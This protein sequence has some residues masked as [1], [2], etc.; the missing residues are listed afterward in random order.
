MYPN[1][2]QRGVFHFHKHPIGQ[3]GK[4]RKGGPLWPGKDS[5]MNQ[6]RPAVESRC[7][8][9]NG[10]NYGM[11]DTESPDRPVRR[12]RGALLSQINVQKNDVADRQLALWT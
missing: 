3:R 10:K 8:S 7:L 6:Q 2:A 5:K 1:P 12:T 11:R 4:T 9:S